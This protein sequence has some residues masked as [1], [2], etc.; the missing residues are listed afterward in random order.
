MTGDDLYSRIVSDR[1]GFEEL[2]AKLPGFRGYMEM[3]A[4]RAADRMIR[5]HVVGKLREQLARLTNIEKMLL[6]AGGLAFMSQTRSVK[7]KFQTYIDRVAAETAGY[8]GFFD[9]L[10][11]GADDLEVI[12][13]FDWALMEYV[14]KFAEKLDALQDAAMNNAG[15]DAL[16]RELDMLTIEANQ[17]FGL[18]DD[19]LKGIE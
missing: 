5:D 2:L 9:A 17:A 16:I 13:A 4:R 10:K 8:S 14:D 11:I 19:V 7:T 3:G 6:D 1:N 15:V 18:R 12:Y